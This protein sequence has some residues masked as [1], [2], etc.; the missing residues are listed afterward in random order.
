MSVNMRISV[1]VTGSHESRLVNAG[2]YIT[3]DFSLAENSLEPARAGEDLTLA[4]GNGST[5]V[6][7]DFFSFSDLTVLADGTE[8]S[9]QSFLSALAPELVTT[10]GALSS[11]GRQPYTDDA[12]KLIGGIEALGDQGSPRWSAPLSRPFIQESGAPLNARSSLLPAAP[13]APAAPQ[14]PAVP[15]TPAAPDAPAAP[16]GDFRLTPGAG[17]VNEALLPGGT[18]RG[19]GSLTADGLFHIAEGSSSISISLGGADTG[20]SLPDAPGASVSLTFPGDHPCAGDHLLITNNGN[21]NYT[22]EYTLGGAKQH[23]APGSATDEI[24]NIRLEVSGTDPEGR[25]FSGGTD[26]SVLDDGISARNDQIVLL[27]SPPQNYYVTIVLDMSTSMNS[28]AKTGL[29]G[30][31][32]TRFEV[33]RDALAQLL[34]EYREARGDV[35]INLVCFAQRGALAGADMSVDEAIKL[36]QDLNKP[37]S[38]GPYGSGT[39][40]AAGLNAAGEWVLKGLQDNAYD[41]YRN[42]VYFISDGEPNRGQQANGRYVPEAW[43]EMAS[44]PY[45]GDLDIYSVGVGAGAR[46]P[47]AEN[48]LKDVTNQDELALDGGDRYVHVDNFGDLA[49][50]LSDLADIASGNLAAGNILGADGVREFYGYTDAA[51]EHI[52]DWSL[53]G[54]GYHKIT[55]FDDGRGNSAVLEIN[56]KGDYILSVHGAPPDRYDNVELILVD[57]DGDQITLRVPIVIEHTE[58]AAF[59]GAAPELTSAALENAPGGELEEAARNFLQGDDGKVL[60]DNAENWAEPVQA[61][62]QSAWGRDVFVWHKESLS[63]AGQ[64]LDFAVGDSDSGDKLFFEGLFTGQGENAQASLDDISAMLRN[65]TLGLEISR[66]GQLT[67]SFNQGED[68]ARTVRINLAEDSCSAL[69]NPDLHSQD[70]AAAEQAKAALLQ[71]LLLTTM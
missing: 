67:V 41:G 70:A 7:R 36:L 60:I 34:H 27:Q 18:G 43:Q 21:G 19:G 62:S 48:A 64:I 12:G 71:N 66:E 46:N 4:F 59:A 28:S 45:A 47:A 30:D 17:A 44:G 54:D 55:L 49:G 2:D 1:P 51:G 56:N 52:I 61:Y 40:Y 23:G 42:Q 25:A 65:G 29:P 14:T 10:A 37:S 13:D 50:I 26:I 15:Q 35:R 24:L 8:L 9:P 16:E 38:G 33:A 11:G 63:G 22:Y 6:L 68:S 58:P 3:L 20:L 39:D 53:V 5:L 69:D 31:T 57:G 32:R